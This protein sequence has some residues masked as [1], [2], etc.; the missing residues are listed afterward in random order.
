[1]V[2]F[3]LFIF[4]HLGRFLHICERFFSLVRFALLFFDLIFDE[5]E[6][7]PYI[8]WN[9]K[10]LIHRLHHI[11]YFF[12]SIFND[13]LNLLFI[14]FGVL[15]LFN[16]FFLFCYIAK[17]RLRDLLFL[18][19]FEPGNVLHFG[20]GTITYQNNLPHFYNRSYSYL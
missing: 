17:E 9:L 8:R 15:C 16:H 3:Y 2:H 18:H 13:F 19:C 14:H 7:N 11:E 20:W 5:T 1:M 6:V 4:V 10:V 12:N